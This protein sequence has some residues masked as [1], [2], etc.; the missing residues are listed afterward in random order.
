VDEPVDVVFP[1]AALHWIPPHDVDRAVASMAAVLK[2]G[3]RFIV[4]FGGKGNVDSIVR[5]TLQVLNFPE[6]ASPWYF[7]SIADFTSILERHGTK[8]RQLC[9]SIDPYY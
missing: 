4:G 1:N 9:F 3:G 2:P 6:I 7:P 8:S 5:A